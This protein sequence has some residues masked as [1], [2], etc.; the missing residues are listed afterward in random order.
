MLVGLQQNIE[1]RE[2]REFLRFPGVSVDEAPGVVT[3]EPPINYIVP[4]IN[5]IASID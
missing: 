4:L 3:S 5:L 1:A 2:T